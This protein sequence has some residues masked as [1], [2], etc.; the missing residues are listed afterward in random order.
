LSTKGC[1]EALKKA[2]AQAKRHKAK[3]DF[4]ALIHHSDR[5]IQYCSYAY[6]G[7]LKQEKIRISMTQSGDPYGNA[8]AERVNRIIKEE[9]LEN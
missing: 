5:G 2:I 6:T 1:A 4:E 3:A 7:M 8:L 9:F